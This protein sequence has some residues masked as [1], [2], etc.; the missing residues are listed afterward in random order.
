MANLN[1]NLKFRFAKTNIK[2]RGVKKMEKNNEKPNIRWKHSETVKVS[3]VTLELTQDETQVKRVKLQTKIGNITYKPKK[4]ELG[5]KEIAGFQ[6][7]FTKNEL[8]GITEFIA[9]NP[10]L[11]QLSKDSKL[12]KDNPEIVLSYAEID[13]YDENDEEIKT[14]K[15]MNKGQFETIYYK[16]FHKDDLSNLEKQK[17]NKKKYAALELEL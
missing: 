14:Y 13:R 8:Y 3:R 16:P 15:F 17:E 10:L 12:P 11:V 6:T 7:E 5:I 4:R 2:Q 9:M 1:K